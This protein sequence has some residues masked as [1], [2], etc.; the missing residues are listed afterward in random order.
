MKATFYFPAHP[1]YFDDKYTQ[2]E[3][4]R[5]IRILD[6]I[7]FGGA[8]LKGTWQ[9]PFEHKFVLLRKPG[10]SVTVVVDSTGHGDERGIDQ[11]RRSS[12]HDLGIYVHNLKDILNGIRLGAPYEE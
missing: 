1:A 5:A 11:Y 3:I 6:K 8:I 4:D 9:K 12:N 10:K 7:Q 2:E